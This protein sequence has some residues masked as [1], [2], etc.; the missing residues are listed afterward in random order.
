MRAHEFITETTSTTLAQLYDGKYPDRDESFW[1]YVRPGEFELPLTIE[2]LPRHRLMIQLLGQYRVEHIDEIVDMLDDDQ[3]EIVDRYRS[4]PNL[5]NKIIVLADN[6]IIDGN[7][8]ALAAALNG[9]S[10][11]Y[12]DLAELGD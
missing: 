9:S 7:H 5:G 11:K 10:I 4:D 2:T 8:R 6:R 12:V 1:D 3:Q